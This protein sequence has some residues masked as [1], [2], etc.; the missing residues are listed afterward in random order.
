MLTIPQPGIVSPSMKRF[1]VHQPL[2]P[3]RLRQSSGNHFTSMSPQKKRV[4]CGMIF[5]AAAD[6]LNSLSPGASGNRVANA[7]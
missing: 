5:E 1:T 6:A 7:R 4:I 3:G 2:L